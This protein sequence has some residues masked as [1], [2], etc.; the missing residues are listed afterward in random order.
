MRVSRKTRLQARLARK[1]AQLELLYDAVDKMVAREISS[2][3]LNTGEADQKI[4]FKS[5]EAI[6]KF[7]T[8]LENEIDHIYRTLQSQNFIRFTTNRR[9]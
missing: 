8:S 5:P 6:R 1:E 4:V 9:M 2:F 3:E 7:T